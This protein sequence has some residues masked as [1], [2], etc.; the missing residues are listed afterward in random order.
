M[1]A[2]QGSG[3][4]DQ[5][6]DGGGGDFDASYRQEQNGFPEMPFRGGRF[7]GRRAMRGTGPAMIR[8]GDMAVHGGNA[9]GGFHNYE[10]P[11][12]GRGR[13]GTRRGRFGRGRRYGGIGGDLSDKNQQGDSENQPQADSGGDAADHPA[14][15]ADQ[16]TGNNTNEAGGLQ[17]EGQGSDGKEK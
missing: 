5:E 3:E 11:S 4:G 1:N 16:Q 14:A 10:R 6:E 13:F 15:K 17:V 12:R 2:S 8:E 9:G 7:R